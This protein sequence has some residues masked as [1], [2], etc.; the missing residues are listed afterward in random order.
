MHNY[1]YPKTSF[2]GNPDL[3]GELHIQT[4]ESPKLPGETFA[5]TYYV[6]GEKVKKF[7][8]DYLKSNISKKLHRKVSKVYTYGDT[9]FTW[10]QCLESFVNITN[11]KNTFRVFASDVIAFINS[12]LVGKLISNIEDLDAEEKLKFIIAVAKMQNASVEKLN[13]EKLEAILTFKKFT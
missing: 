8:L 13:Y 1:S 7:V 6:D 2:N 9:S 11:P 5:Q 12:Y 4:D 3:S 10:D